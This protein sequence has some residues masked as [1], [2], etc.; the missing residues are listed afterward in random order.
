[1]ALIRRLRECTVRRSG[2]TSVSVCDSERRAKEQQLLS[3][4]QYTVPGDVNVILFETFPLFLSVL[5]HKALQCE[6]APWL[7]RK[8]LHRLHNAAIRLHGSGGVI[9]TGNATRC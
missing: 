5:L 3:I 9:I 2:A 1:M 7:L 8:Q 4:V 6:Y